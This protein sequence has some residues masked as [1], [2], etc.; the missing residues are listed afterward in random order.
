MWASASITIN[1]HVPFNFHQ[2]KTEQ[3]SNA[4]PRITQLLLVR[5]V[6]IIYVY[7]SACGEQN[8]QYTQ[9][10]YLV[11]PLQLIVRKSGWHA[12]KSKHFVAENRRLSMGTYLLKHTNTLLRIY[13]W[14]MKWRKRD[15]EREWKEERN[16]WVSA[17]RSMRQRQ[18]DKVC[19]SSMHTRTLRI[20]C[21]CAC[22]YALYV[23]RI[24]NGATISIRKHCINGQ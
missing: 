24:L 1:T 2:C 6:R 7:V 21:C 19:C 16:Y 15:R 14:R 17:L 12:M 5:L 8:T 22:L 20:L 13:V 3:N 10:N 11:L 4:F 9:T 18:F 23:Y